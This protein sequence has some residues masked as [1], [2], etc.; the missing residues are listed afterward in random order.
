MNDIL[1]K[2]TDIIETYE[3]GAWVTED[4]LRIMHRELTANIF[5]LT[6]FNIE[7]FKNHNTI[8]YNHKGS[9]SSGLI[10]ANEQVSELRMLR[11]IESTAN[12]VVNA[13]R[14]EITSLRNSK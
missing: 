1:N 2:I 7:A 6:K 13:M 3:S 10:I 9:V 8:Q 14:S 4:N 11:K 12:N 5:F